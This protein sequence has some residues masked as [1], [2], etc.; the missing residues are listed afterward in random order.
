MR[1]GE[2]PLQSRLGSSKGRAECVGIVVCDAVHRAQCFFAYCVKV[3]VADGVIAAAAG[4]VA[5]AR[6]SVLREQAILYL[7]YLVFALRVFRLQPSN[8]TFE[9][10]GFSLRLGPSGLERLF[11]PLPYS[12]PVF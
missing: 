11:Q 9:R 12:Y 5:A 6:L 3:K 8:K 7:A 10:E 4:N 1:I 2:E